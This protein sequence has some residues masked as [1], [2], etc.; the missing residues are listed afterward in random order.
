MDMVAQVYILSTGETKT[1]RVQCSLVNQLDY[2]TKYG[3]MG[4]SVSKKIMWLAPEELNPKLSLEVC[5]HTCVHTY[6]ERMGNRQ[7]RDH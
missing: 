3:T 4:D 1:G 2:L 6:L 7:P 5:M